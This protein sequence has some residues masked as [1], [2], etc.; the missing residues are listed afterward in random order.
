MD[1]LSVVV[2]GAGPV[3]LAAAAHLL[4][5]GLRPLVLEA[6]PRAGAAVAQWRHVRLFSQWSELVD[7]AARR[8][9]EPTGWR[10]PDPDGYPTGEQWAAEYLE[11]LAQA[12]G[13]H[14][15]LN[16]RVVG[17][18]RRGRDRVVDAGRDSEPLTVHVEG[19]ERIT[20]RAVVDASGTWGGPNPLGGDGLPAAGEREAADRIGYRVP[21]VVGEQ[22]R[23]A[24]RRVAVAGSGHSALTAL[25]A[26]A[27]LAERHPGTRVTWLLRRGAVGAV[28]GGGEA[29]QLPAR[30]ALGLRARAAVRAGHV[31]VVTGFRTAAVERAGERLVLVSQ[32]G[33]RLDPV[34]EVVSLTGFRPDHSW[35]SE[36]RLGLDPVLQ[37]PTGLAP[38]VDPNV[39][40]CGSVPPHG[41]GELRHPEP[42]VYLVGM[43][44]YGRAPTFLALTGYEQ[45]RSVAAEI[46]GDHESAARVELTLPGTGVCGGSGVFDV[47]PASAGGCCATPRV[48]ELTLTAPGGRV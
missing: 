32:D 41:A 14:V 19:G 29:D 25:V 38:L 27:D 33:H 16:A 31:E 24:G 15:R 36:V 26:L 2:V 12:L 20:A 23:Y 35:L 5:R 9:L 30:G 44:S 48:A 40:S 11:P 37:A 39:H 10:F 3:G 17:V 6:G 46:A 28:F 42:G 21:D 22:A 45:V 8:L 18:A 1:E 4:E 43:K 34:D 47:E 13:E 7:P